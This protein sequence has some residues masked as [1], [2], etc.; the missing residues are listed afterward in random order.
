M[1]R[2]GEQDPPAIAAKE[3]EIKI[4]AR[5]RK[6]MPLSGRLSLPFFAYYRILTLS[7]VSLLKYDDTQL[8]QIQPLTDFCHNE[9][10]HRF[11]FHLRDRIRKIQTPG[12]PTLLVRAQ[13][14]QIN[15]RQLM[16]EHG[17]GR[18]RLQFLAQADAHFPGSLP[19]PRRGEPPAQRPHRLALDQDA[20]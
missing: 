20:I 16:A 6:P 15:V 13:M 5:G 2:K 18:R 3:S 4:F 1:M 17:I 14:T 19:R 8:A 12:P 9:V 11:G 7:A 10:R